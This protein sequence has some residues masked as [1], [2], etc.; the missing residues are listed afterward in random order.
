MSVTLRAGDRSQP[1]QDVCLAGFFSYG[2][3]ATGARIGV[4]Y[5]QIPVNRPK[6]PVHS[7][8]KDGRMAGRECVRPGVRAELQG[9]TEGRFPAQYPQVEGVGKAS[10]EFIH[11]RLHQAEG[12]R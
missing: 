2:R 6:A 3:R 9:R 10:G 5:K 12:R 4:N 11:A 1:G 8:S 7:Y